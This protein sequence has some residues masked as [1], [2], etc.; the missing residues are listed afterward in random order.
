MLDTPP[1]APRPCSL[2]SALCI[3]STALK[4]HASDAT[5]LLDPAPVHYA[6]S[7]TP[8]YTLH[9]KLAAHLS[10]LGLKPQ[11]L[12]TRSLSQPEPANSCAPCANS[13]SLPFWHPP[14]AR[15]SS[16]QRV[17]FLWVWRSEGA[18]AT[19]NPGPAPVKHQARVRDQ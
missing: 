15:N 16:H 18:N 14:V 7:P 13:H 12:L 6:S 17:I 4:P 8:L 3:K 19:C 2:F 9:L 1:S 11:R 10:P 5:P